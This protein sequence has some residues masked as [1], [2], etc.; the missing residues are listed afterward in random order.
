M[1]SQINFDFQDKYEKVLSNGKYPVLIGKPPLE[2]IDIHG[3]KIGDKIIKIGGDGI[4]G[5]KNS[6]SS[7]VIE[8]DKPIVYS[9]IIRLEYFYMAFLHYE[10]CEGKNVYLLFMTD[11]DHDELILQDLPGL[12]ILIHRAIFKK[13]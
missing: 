9:G 12:S 5:G 3:L 6:S 4:K 11:F 7:R 8:F 1:K 13:I 10:K 2:L